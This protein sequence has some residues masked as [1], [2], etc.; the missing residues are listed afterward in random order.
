MI[1]LLLDMERKLFNFLVDQDLDLSVNLLHLKFDLLVLNRLELFPRLHRRLTLRLIL[2]LAF[3]LLNQ[4]GDRLDL[5]L[6][7]FKSR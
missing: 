5:F 6:L 3:R 2:Q 1:Q 4:L 7:L